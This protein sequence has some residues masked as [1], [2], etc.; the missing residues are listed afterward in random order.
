M[1]QFLARHKNYIKFLLFLMI[2][3][4]FL[5]ISGVHIVHGKTRHMLDWQIQ[6]GGSIAFPLFLILKSMLAILVGF[7]LATRTVGFCERN[8]KH[9]KQINPTSQSILINILQIFI[10]FIFFVAV[11]D[12]LN[13]QSSSIA[14]VSGA[15]AFGLSLGLRQI[16]SNLVS[17]FVLLLERSVNVGDFVE[18]KD[19]GVGFVRRIGTLYTHIEITDGRE[20]FIPNADIFNHL[21]ANWT[22]NHRQARIEFEIIIDYVTDIA[23]V[24]DICY[25]AMNTHPCKSEHHAPSFFVDRFGDFGLVLKMQFW[26]DDIFLGRNRVKSELLTEICTALQ[27][28]K[29]RIPSS[30]MIPK[31]QL[32]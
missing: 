21:S 17:G 30:A 4:G 32:A 22:L 25:A 18:T 2:A 28:R 7:W 11:L 13:F 27:K 29:I 5:Y 14:V 8:I 12:I 24:R 9:F 26:L 10:Y 1:I 20:I 3:I 31:K 15:A 16:A 23:V 19:Q 6:I